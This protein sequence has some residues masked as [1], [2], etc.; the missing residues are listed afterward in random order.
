MNKL[1]T[2]ITLLCFSFVANA[3]QY[4][5]VGEKASYLTTI[6]NDDIYDTSD[7]RLVIDFEKGYRL[8]GIPGLEDYSGVCELTSNE[9]TLF[10]CTDEIGI[11]LHTITAYKNN[12][13]PITFTYVRQT[14]QTV[15]ARLGSC[16][17]I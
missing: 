4:L 14:G 3:E 8:V 11:T 9:E 7:T 12:N 13:S 2:T 15:N 5:C 16:T 1:L 6:G 17:E 10:K